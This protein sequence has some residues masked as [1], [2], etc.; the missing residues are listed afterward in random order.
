MHFVRI[1]RGVI[2]NLHEIITIEK[3]FVTT[4]DLNEF[5]YTQSHRDNL[6]KKLNAMT[7][8]L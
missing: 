3:D 2:I 6:R 7:I 5:H 8:E 1:N 4:S